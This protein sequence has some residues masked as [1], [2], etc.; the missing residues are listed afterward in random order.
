MNLPGHD[1][2]NREH[3]AAAGREAIG[4]VKLSQRLIADIDAWAEAHNI[5]RSTH[6]QAR[7]EPSS[8]NW[9]ISKNARSSRSDGCS[10]PRCPPRSGNAAPAA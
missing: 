6:R 3:A 1:D 7:I 4:A 5:A 2:S 8:A 9:P 10:I